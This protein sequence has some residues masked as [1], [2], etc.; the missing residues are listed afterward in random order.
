VTYIYFCSIIET[1]SVSTTSILNFMSTAGKLWKL[2]AFSCYYW[3]T[4]H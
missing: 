2:A 1:F 3:D 4:H